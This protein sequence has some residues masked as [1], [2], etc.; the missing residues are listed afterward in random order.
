MEIRERLVRALRTAGMQEVPED[1]HEELALHGMDSLMMVL[2]V[3]A[4]EKELELRIPAHRFSEDA[5]R[6]LHTLEEFLRGLG[7]R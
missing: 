7:A 2:S 1:T 5:F 4:L 6:T 3:A